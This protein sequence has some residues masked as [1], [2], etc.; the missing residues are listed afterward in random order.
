MASS[1]ALVVVG[2]SSVCPGYLVEEGLGA[3]IRA[4][5][6]GE[7]VAVPEE[8]RASSRACSWPSLAMRWTSLARIPRKSRSV[9]A[10]M[11]AL[12]VDFGARPEAL[13]VL[14]AGRPT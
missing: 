14:A 11:A 1:P 10:G 4:E 13:A 2:A 3:D 7:L 9:V 12:K 8:A 5:R 6:P